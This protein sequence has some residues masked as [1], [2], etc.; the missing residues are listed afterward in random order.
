[1]PRPCKCR[2]IARQPPASAFKPGGIPGRQLDVIEL[3]LDE[4][5]ALRLADLEGLYH[6]AAAA[7][8]GV[9]RP[10]FGRLLERARHKVACA[11]LRSKMLVF[12]G[13]P[14]M[15]ANARKFQCA[16]CGAEF[17]APHT[18]GRP[19]EC[20]QCHGANFHRAAEQRGQGRRGG[21]GAGASVGACGQG[22]CV[23]RRRSWTGVSERAENATVKAEETP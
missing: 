9:S 2:L 8:M 5:E 15:M 10:T 7:R 17:Q 14:I 18:T 13:G 11:L 16:D 4:L 23:R 20:P 12:K 22:R 1:M 6:D 3:G 19:A 21:R